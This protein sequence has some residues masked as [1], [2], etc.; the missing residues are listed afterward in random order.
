MGGATSQQIDR[1]L[2][3][4]E[5]VA[6]EVYLHDEPLRVRATT[7]N[8]SR[9]GA[10]I[11]VKRNNLSVGSLVDLVFVRREGKVINLLRYTAIVIHRYEGGLGLRFCTY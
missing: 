2:E 7:L 9:Y 10:S 5:V 6:M 8:I 11:A 4:R 3:S 1:R